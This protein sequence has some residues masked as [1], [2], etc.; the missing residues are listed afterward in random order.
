MF[1]PTVEYRLE[2]IE[3]RRRYRRWILASQIVMI[4][5][6]A[7]QILKTWSHGRL[8]EG[9]KRPLLGQTLWLGNIVDKNLSEVGASAPVN[10]NEAIPLRLM[11]TTALLMIG[12]SAFLR[13]K[14][15]T[16]EI[17][18]IA[19]LIGGSLSRVLDA[20]RTNHVFDTLVLRLGADHF[21]A[22]SLAELAIGLGGICVL[23]SVVR[24]L[25]ASGI[26]ADGLETLRA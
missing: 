12:I 9:A 5:F 6:F 10:S 23:W 11:T 8:V 1:F 26:S 16:L 7:D 21:Y 25:F 3:K 15:A 4:V 13:R 18:G 20:W 17:Y 24:Q 2:R 14:G 19:Y 22:F